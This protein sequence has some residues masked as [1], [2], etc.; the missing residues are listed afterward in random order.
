MPFLHEIEVIPKG[1]AGE[2]RCGGGNQT[3]E[4]GL[5]IPV[6]QLAFAG[7]VD[8][9]VDGGQ[10]QILPDGESLL[11]FGQMAIQE[12]DESDLLG[13]IIEGHDVAEGCDVHGLGLGNQPLLLLGGRGDEIVGGTEIDGADNLGLPVNALAFAGVVVGFSVNDLGGEAGHRGTPFLFVGHT[14]I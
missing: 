2:L 9:P 14:N 10:E 1:L 12:F 8:G 6:G 5:S 4:G 13:Q 11:A 7:G 3:G